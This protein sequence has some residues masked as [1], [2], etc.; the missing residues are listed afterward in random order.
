MIQGAELQ[1]LGLGED[2][3]RT[4]EALLRQRAAKPEELA[5]VLGI[6]RERLNAALTR[7]SDHGFTTPGDATSALPTRRPRRPRSAPS[8]TAARPNSTFVPPNW[9]A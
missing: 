3:E 8:S 7:L 5:R 9:S 2:E 1:D 6:P 4:Y